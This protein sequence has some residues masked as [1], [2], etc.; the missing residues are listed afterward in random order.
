[1]LAEILQATLEVGARLDG[2]G[3]AWV[4]GGS[5]AS[6]VLGVP[7]SIQDVD[8]VAAPESRHVAGLIAAEWSRCS[9]GA[10]YPS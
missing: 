10:L 4:V 8:I 5:F 2:L 1:M 9:P 6:S 7:R 3:V